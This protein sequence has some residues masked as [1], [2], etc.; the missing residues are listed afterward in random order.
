MIFLP[1]LF[2]EFHKLLVV[3]FIFSAT[4]IIRVNH[5]FETFGKFGSRTVSMKHLHKSSLNV[6]L[7]VV[8][9]NRLILSH[10]DLFPQLFNINFRK[11][12]FLYTFYHVLIRFLAHI[13][14]ESLTCSNTTIK[15][16]I[17]FLSGTSDFFI[18]DSVVEKAL[19][20]HKRCKFIIAPILLEDFRL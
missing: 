9:L 19:Q 14:N 1:K 2:K 4:C 17:H 12:N 8:N 7:Q 6:F 3:I 11:V 20:I 18:I 13:I 16:L 5:P 15:N 10:L